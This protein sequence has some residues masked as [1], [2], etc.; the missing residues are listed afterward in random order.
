[1]LYIIADILLKMA[2]NANKADY[3]VICYNSH[4]ADSGIN[5]Q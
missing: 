4:I 3:H 2:L 5:H 1:M